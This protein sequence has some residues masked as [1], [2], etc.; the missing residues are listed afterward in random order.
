[1]PRLCSMSAKVNPPMPPPAMRMVICHPRESGDPAVGPERA[2]A[3]CGTVRE[4]C[5]AANPSRRVAS[6]I[7]AFARMTRVPVERASLRLLRRR[8]KVDLVLGRKRDDLG[9]RLLRHVVDAP[10]EIVE[11][12]GRR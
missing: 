5:S 4:R 9:R 8:Q 12:A 10:E 7:L 2:G 6:W 11:T 1:M 3:R